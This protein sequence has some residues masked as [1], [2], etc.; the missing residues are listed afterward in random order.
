MNIICNHLSV[1]TLE[2]RKSNKLEKSQKR[3]NDFVKYQVAG[4]R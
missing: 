1:Y 2:I 3:F 4:K